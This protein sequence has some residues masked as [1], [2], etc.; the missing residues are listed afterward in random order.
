MGYPGKLLA[1]GEQIALEMRP[2]WR[3]MVFPSI[4]LVLTVAVAS[5]VEAIVPD[6]TL[7]AAIRWA[8]LALAVVLL[9]VW[10]VRPALVW[11]TTQYVF[12]SRRIITRS[13]VIAR[14]GKDMPYS[15]VNDV[16]FEYTI[17]ERILRCGTLTVSSASDDGG[18]VIRNVPK[19]E[20]IQR[21]IYRLSE[22]DAAR[23][24]QGSGDSAPA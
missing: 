17:I 20:E 1:Q 24:H 13:G 8:V 14:R 19:V 6:G 3:S 2:H 10:F 5:F 9:I 23:R 11:L 16:S 12:T 21:E 15:K 22:A 7:Q 4:A 18:L